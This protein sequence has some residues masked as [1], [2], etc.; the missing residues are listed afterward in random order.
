MAF[1]L[2]AIVVFIGHWVWTFVASTGFVLFME[3]YGLDVCGVHNVCSVSE[4]FSLVFFFF[5]YLVFLFVA[6]RNG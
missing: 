3:C 6:W 2:V 5:I 1:G 4:A